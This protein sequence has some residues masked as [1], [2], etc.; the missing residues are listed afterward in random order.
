MYERRKPASE[1]TPEYED[2]GIFKNDLVQ[3]R[4]ELVPLTARN[5]RNDL[6]V[7]GFVDGNSAIDV[8]FPGRRT[9]QAK[10]I[11]ALLQAKLT[12]AR[13]TAER[14]GAT[15]DVDK[16]RY[17]AMV[18]GAWRPRFK[19]DENGWETRQHQLFVARWILHDTNGK[20]ITFG[21]MKVAPDA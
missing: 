2:G 10:P 5:S 7:K 1:I 12:H 9:I 20:P 15:L 19:R 18:E 8:V 6:I 16:V 11:V 14:T 17:P 3:L 21:E 13:K 4:I